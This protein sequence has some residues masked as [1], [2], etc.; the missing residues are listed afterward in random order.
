MDRKTLI[1]VVI[2]LVLFMAYPLLLRWAG[3]DRYMR[4]GTNP[5]KEA[6]SATTA[7]RDTGLASPRASASDTGAATALA[8]G[9][10]ATSSPAQA[11]EHLVTVETPLYRAFFSTRGARLLGVELKRYATAQGAGREQ[12]RRRPKPGDEWPEPD[13]VALAGSPTFALDLGSGATRRHLDDVTYEVAD[14]LDAAGQA[15]TL[16]FTARTPE[17]ATV[18]QT[19]HIRPDDYAID[20]DVQIQDVPFGWR[21]DDYSL[22]T[23]SWALEHENDAVD[24]E[25]SLKVTS[26]VGANHHRDL[27]GALRHGPKVFEGSVGWT[28]VQTRCVGRWPRPKPVP[29]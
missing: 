1:A 11:P 18:R 3:L 10:T 12:G 4:P 28:A 14:S 22:T 21:V 19:F 15:R 17:G 8:A 24:E 23:R 16:R 13:R 9:A 5:P 7:P 20:L 6:P 29:V 2:C 26:L 27:I 25:R